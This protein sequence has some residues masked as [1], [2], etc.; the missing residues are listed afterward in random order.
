[1]VKDKEAKFWLAIDASNLEVAYKMCNEIKKPYAYE[2]LKEEAKRQ[3]N[4]NIV[5]ICS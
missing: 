4:H 1:M 2:A 5:E 3:G